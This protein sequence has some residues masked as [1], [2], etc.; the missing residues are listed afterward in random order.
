MARVPGHSR[1]IALRC[2][3]GTSGCIGAWPGSC[4]LRPRRGK[5][6]KRR[7]RTSSP[8]S[9]SRSGGWWLPRVDDIV[10]AWPG[11][12]HSSQ[13]L[14]Q[15]GGKYFAPFPNAYHPVYVTLFLSAQIESR[16][17]AKKC[18]RG[19]QSQPTAHIECSQPPSLTC[20]LPQEHDVVHQWL[21]WRCCGVLVVRSRPSH[22]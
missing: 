14:S 10:G 1:F 8:S 18:Q 6:N 9:A 22:A 12:S 11:T 7:K 4:C 3:D 2:A 19:L 17:P 13:E 20:S 5:G 15:E 16:I 21:G